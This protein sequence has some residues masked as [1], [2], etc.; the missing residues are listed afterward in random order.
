M[1]GVSSRAYQIGISKTCRNGSEMR[2][3]PRRSCLKTSATPRRLDFQ[4][5]MRPQLTVRSAIACAS[6]A[7]VFRCRLDFI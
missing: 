5:A 7:A 2:S 1:G 3:H 4:L 6:L